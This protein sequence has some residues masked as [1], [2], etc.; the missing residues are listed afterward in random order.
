[1]IPVPSSLPSRVIRLLDHYLC[2][3]LG[4]Q[5]VPCPYWADDLIHHR[6]P[7]PGGGKGTPEEIETL[8]HNLAKKSHLDLSNLSVSDI[9]RFMRRQHLG[10]DCSGFAYH[11]LNAFDQA[12]SRQ[13]LAGKLTLTPGG[14]PLNQ[15]RYRIDAD[16]FT[17]SENSYPINSITASKPGDLIRMIR[18]KHLLVILEVKPDQITYAH[19]SNLTK[20]TGVHLAT[21]KLINPE[22][23]LSSQKWHELTRKGENFGQKYFKPSQG[24]AVF[25][26]KIWK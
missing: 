26:L 24:D 21:I 17:R 23:D 2:L 1:M 3:K 11:L 8:T 10:V 19:S 7:T 4:H 16:Y 18:G 22:K 6:F 15:D 12:Q 25:R 13:G 9:R 5:C 20:T 14:N